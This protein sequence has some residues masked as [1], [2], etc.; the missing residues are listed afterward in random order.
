MVVRGSASGADPLAIGSADGSMF[1]GNG[2]GG[3]CAPGL[4]GTSDGVGAANC[5][6]IEAGPISA[7]SGRLSEKGKRSKT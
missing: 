5:V 2:A 6:D 1:V 3:M 4:V 7:S